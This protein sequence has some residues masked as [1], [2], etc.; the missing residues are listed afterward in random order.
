MGTRQ[1]AG[2]VAIIALSTIASGSGAVLAHPSIQV[3]E[4]YRSEVLPDALFEAALDAALAPPSDGVSFWSWPP[5]AEQESKR[6]VLAR[7]TR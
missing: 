1:W 7:R 3:K 2:A 4:A 6:D 5:L